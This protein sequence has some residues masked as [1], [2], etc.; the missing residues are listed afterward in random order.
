MEELVSHWYYGVADDAQL[1]RRYRVIRVGIHTRQ[2]T[3]TPV[4]WE[5]VYWPLFVEVAAHDNLLLDWELS[6]I[7]SATQEKT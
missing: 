7:W 5:G 2:K 3:N 1:L 4:E 6:R